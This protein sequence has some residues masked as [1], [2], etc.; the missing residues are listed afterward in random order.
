MVEIALTGVFV[1]DLALTDVIQYSE[2][3]HLKSAHEKVGT[4]H[5]KRCV[6]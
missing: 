2:D 3:L 6:L 4:L 1:P 5:M